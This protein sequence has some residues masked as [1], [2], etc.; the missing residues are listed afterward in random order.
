M[1]DFTMEINCTEWAF[2]YVVYAGPT[3]IRLLSASGGK[4]IESESIELWQRL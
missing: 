4:T 3:W 2:V 1:I